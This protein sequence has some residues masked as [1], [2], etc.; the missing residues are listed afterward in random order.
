MST[1]D[2]VALIRW[3]YERFNEQDLNSL[4]TMI[5]DDVEWPDVVNGTV[6]HGRDEVRAYFERIFSVS[7][8]RATVGDVIEIGDAVVATTYQ[9]FYDLSGKPLGEPRVV[10]NRYNF[11][12]DLISAMVLTAQ[13]DIP[14]EVRRRYLED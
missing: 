8:I 14:D 7:G 11:R 12:D 5:V 9:Q 13:N 4:M 2:R 3:G 10:V 6:L 1:V